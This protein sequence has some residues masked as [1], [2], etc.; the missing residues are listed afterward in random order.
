MSTKKKAISK[1]T[2]KN[3]RRWFCCECSSNNE[4]PVDFGCDHCQDA[5][6]LARRKSGNE[7]P[8]RVYEGTPE[9]AEEFSYLNKK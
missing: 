9:W 6:T 7:F 2:T 4:M 3:N 5:S 8:G 1:K